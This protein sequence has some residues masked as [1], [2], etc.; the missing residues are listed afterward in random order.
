MS[1]K[2][3]GYQLKGAQWHCPSKSD[4]LSLKDDKEQQGGNQKVASIKHQAQGGHEAARQRAW[5]K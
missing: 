5:Q 3:K 2:D 4:H 1:T